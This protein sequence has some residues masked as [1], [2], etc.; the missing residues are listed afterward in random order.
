LLTISPY[1]LEARDSKI[2]YFFDTCPQASQAGYA[3]DELFAQDAPTP[4]QGMHHPQGILAFFGAGIP[5]GLAM[6][7]C[8]NLDIAPTV[9]S[10]LDIAVPPEM[11]GRRLLDTE[12][13][14][15]S[16]SARLAPALA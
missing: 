3:I 15:V 6:N 7:P 12:A 14:A 9:L 8:S 11:K 1:G 16:A 4:K 10:L 2:R 13:S 5:R